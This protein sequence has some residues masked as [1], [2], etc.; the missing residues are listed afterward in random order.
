MRMP[1]WCEV[2]LL[3]VFC[4]LVLAVCLKLG[5]LFARLVIQTPSGIRPPS[6]WQ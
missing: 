3:V 6:V 2:V 5:E 4:T 1:A